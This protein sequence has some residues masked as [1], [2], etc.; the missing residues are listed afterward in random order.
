MVNEEGINRQHNAQFERFFSYTYSF[1]EGPLRTPSPEIPTD[2]RSS[3]WPMLARPNSRASAS[4]TPS[5]CVRASRRS[6]RAH[7]PT[8]Y[9]YSFIILAQVGQS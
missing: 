4:L 5:R 1:A 3:S 6:R 9:R 2:I 7:P 8:G